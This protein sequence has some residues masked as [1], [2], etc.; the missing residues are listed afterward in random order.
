MTEQ[1]KQDLKKLINSSDYP[2]YLRELIEKYKTCNC[3]K[4]KC[5]DDKLKDSKTII[6][7]LEEFEKLKTKPFK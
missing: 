7:T 4:N 5:K 1:E 6:L 3:G 2:E